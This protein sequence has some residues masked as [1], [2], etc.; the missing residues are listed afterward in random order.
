MFALA[1]QPSPVGEGDPRMWGMRRLNK[2]LFF[3]QSEKIFPFDQCKI[4]IIIIF[5]KYPLHS[6]ILQSKYRM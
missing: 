4:N 1:Y 3:E 6:I 2:I 5:S